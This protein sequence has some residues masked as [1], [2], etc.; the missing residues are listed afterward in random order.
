MKIACLLGLL[1]LFSLGAAAQ[2]VS[3]TVRQ[4]GSPVSGSEVTLTLTVDRSVKITTRSD[5]SGKFSFSNVPPG[6]YSLQASAGAAMQAAIDIDV[7]AGENVVRELDLTT[8]PGIRESVTISTDTKQTMEEVSKT[9]NVVD[10]QELRDRADFSL[11]ETL[12]TIPGFRV[13]QLGGFGRTANIKTRGLRNQD[14]AILIDGVRFRDA[15]AITGDA[16]AFLSDIT[17]TSV[18]RIEVLR[19]SGSSLYGTN[20]IGGTIDFQTPEPRHGFHGQVSGALGELGLGRFRG[21]ISDGTADGKF[22]F[23]SGI[24]R[25]VYTKGIDGQ[26]NAHNTNFQ[27]RIEYKP[28]ERTSLSARFFVSDAFVRLNTEPDT[29]GTLPASNSEIIR[30]IPDVSF[31]ADQNDPDNSQRSQ[32]F[33]GQFV[34]THVFND[35][36]VGYAYYSGLRTS[37]KNDN[38]PEG[39]GFQSASTSVFKGTINTFNGHVVWTPNKF[40]SV[41]GGYEFESEKFGNDGFTPAGTDNFFSRA[42]QSSNTI[43]I[44]DLVMLLDDTLQLAGSVRAQFFDLK[45]PVFS[46][47]NAPYASLELGHPPASYTFDGSASYFIRRSG[48][49][50]RFHA[51]NGYRIPSLFE[52]FGTFFNAFAFPGPRFEALGDPFLK[53]ERT[54]AGDVGIEQNFSGEKGRI[55]AVYFYTKLLDTISFG[56]VVPDIGSTH[57]DFGGYFNTKGG[58]SRGIEISGKY[59]PFASTDIFASY[60]FTNSDQ[61]TPQI[62]GNLSIETLGI[63][64]HQYSLVATH[65]IGRFWINVDLLATSSYLAPIFDTNGFTF[66]SYVYRFRGNRKADLTAGYTFPIKGDG[67]NLR[68]YGTLENLADDHYYENGFRTPGRNARIGLTF[69]F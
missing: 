35:N 27:S 29:A 34:L 21:N 33:N 57:R 43:Y 10:A 49:K 31:I 63:P 42:K 66:R 32:F 65:R 24:S 20:A 58:I 9:V 8:V 5:A 30:A 2:S 61:R 16:S 12:R 62:A 25:T 56:N 15:S 7:K 3:G 6:S 39:P 28:F 67:V 18:K 22:G 14:T 19:G 54:I 68:L 64:K 38:G 45:E 52:R 37:R 47:T 17:L 51:G 46:A 40:N 36:L 59:V 26:D 11:T 60:T 48:T 53:P 55:T 41:M 50:L 13:Q 44:Q 1:L 4:N 23:T 69:N